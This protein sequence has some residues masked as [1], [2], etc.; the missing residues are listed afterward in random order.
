MKTKEQHLKSIR[1]KFK[2]DTG[3]ELDVAQVDFIYD[4]II[5]PKYIEFLEN[6]I[7]ELLMN[8]DQ[9]FN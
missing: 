9:D 4:F 3:E 2:S 7:L 5:N 6:Y 1:D 8:R